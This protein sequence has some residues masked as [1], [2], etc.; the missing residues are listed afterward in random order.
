MNIRHQRIIDL[1]LTQR[2]V[3]VVE[4]AELLKV[5]P[6]T[7]RRDLET[8]ERDG[9]LTRT[10]GGAIFSRSAMFEFA[11]LD[12]VENRTIEKKAIAKSITDAINPGMT[13]ILDTGTTTLEVAHAIA[14]IPHLRVLTSSLA[15]ASAL[16]PYDNIDLVLLGGS[17]RRH[18]PD[19]SGPLTEENL[20]MFKT[21]IVILGADAVCNDGIFTTDLDIARISR[22]MIASAQESW[23]VVDSSKFTRRSFVKFAEW[24]AINNV[25]TDDGITRSDIKWINESGCKL[26]IAST[27]IIKKVAV[28]K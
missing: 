11:F 3:S 14:V 9:E 1:L 26:H 21:D 25:V 19:L 12:R 10:H 5:S 17:V 24:T 13:I 15:I 23:L 20:R 8:L 16:H 4:L 22:A 18:S 2:E 6:I 7:I 28:N 27:K